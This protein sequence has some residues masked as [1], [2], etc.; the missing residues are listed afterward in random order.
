MLLL[1]LVANVAARVV[2]HPACPPLGEF[3]AHSSIVIMEVSTP[4]LARSGLM[5][6][7][8]VAVH[9]SSAAALI[10]VNCHTKHV[11]VAFRDFDVSLGCALARMDA[12]LQSDDDALSERMRRLV[13]DVDGEWPATRACARWPD[14]LVAFLFW[15]TLA[16]T[17]CVYVALLR[18]AKSSPA[19]SEPRQRRKAQ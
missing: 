10:V 16:A 13:D 12:S 9:A 11:A 5:H 19:S 8:A 2:T 3:L 14:S 17:R 7:A 18:V 1:F 4:G 6:E 15:S